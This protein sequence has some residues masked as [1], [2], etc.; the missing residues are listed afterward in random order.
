V[1]SALRAKADKS[2]IIWSRTKLEEYGSLTPEGMAKL[3]K[4]GSPAINRGE[5]AGDAVV[6][7]HVLP[8]AVVP[9]LSA[10]FLNLEAIPAKTNREKSP[11]IGRRELDLARRWHREGLAAVAGLAA[12]EKAAEK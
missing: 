4:G 8:V 3:R 11:K 2:A 12:V 9:E 1:K 7:D 6:L 5:H 10:R